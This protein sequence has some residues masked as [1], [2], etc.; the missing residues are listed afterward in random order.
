MTLRSNK[1]GTAA[2]AFIR[3]RRMA[4]P[5]VAL[6]LLP[7]PNRF[8]LEFIPIWLIM[9]PFTITSM[10]APPRLDDGPTRLNFGSSIALLAASTTGK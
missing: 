9:G 7:G 4:R 10:A 8:P 1:P 5:M 2:Q 6:A 3:I